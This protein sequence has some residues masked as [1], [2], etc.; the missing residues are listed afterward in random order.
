MIDITVATNREMGL[1]QVEYFVVI[2]SSSTL[3]IVGPRLSVEGAPGT[4]LIPRLSMKFETWSRCPTSGTLGEHTENEGGA[5]KRVA[6]GAI[7]IL[8]SLQIFGTAD[9]AMATGNLSANIYGLTTGPTFQS[10]GDRI[11]RY[12]SYTFT[13]VNGSSRDVDVRHIGQNGPG[14]QLLVAVRSGT[15][16]KLVPLTG[17]GKIQIVPA[18]R[19][20][21]LTVWFHVSNCTAVP[22]SFWPLTMDAGWSTKKLQRVSLQMSSASSLQW[23]KSLSDSVCS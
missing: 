22:K 18:H 1:N 2:V 11:H 13:L 21:R 20:I 7:L 17:L 16:S 9:L 4:K 6:T 10:Y 14:L 19:S 8:A 15:G 3:V 23:Q 12:V 5:M